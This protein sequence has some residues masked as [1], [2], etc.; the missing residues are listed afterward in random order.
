MGIKTIQD[1][2]HTEYTAKPVGGS[3]AAQFL[4]EAME[5]DD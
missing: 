2:L 1:A 4:Q 3:I 5:E